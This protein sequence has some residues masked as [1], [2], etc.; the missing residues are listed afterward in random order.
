MGMNLRVGHSS[1]RARS[2]F[3]LVELLVVIAII[4]VLVALLLPA[5]Q[6]AREAARRMQCTNN[7]KQMG[8]GIH[9]FHDTNN[10]LP[11]LVR[12]PMRATFFVE[13][14]PFL[15]QTNAYNLL[16]GSNVN[17]TK[18]DIGLDMEQNWARLTIEER[19]ALGSIKY[20]TCPSRR[21]PGFRDVEGGTGNG[22]L[23]DYAAVFVLGD[24]DANG[25]F[26][27]A[28][29]DW[30]NHYN[31]CDTS[32]VARQKGALEVAQ[33]NCGE[34]NIDIRS[35]NA[36]PRS[37]FERMRDGTSNTFVL[38]EKHVRANEFG[39]CCAGGQ[40]DG[41]YLLQNGGWREYLVA[42][43]IQLRFG[44][45]PSDNAGNPDNT[46]G[47]GSYH[48]GVCH[49]LR[50]DGSVAS[51]SNNVSHNIVSRLG[52]VSDGFSVQLD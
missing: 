31:P 52:H 18:T 27:Q 36:R 22:P 1:G 6:A 39:K 44:K 14:M 4:G 19:K 21:A 29:G 38:G 28:V 49:F 9:N 47:F 35:R 37:G 24:P 10:G 13:I 48:P 34:A 26:S 8:L 32:H 23:G 15:E 12:G 16:N 7:I 46:F 45:G 41:T 20:M 3:T 33:V 43:N 40:T 11:P 42:R 25:N 50:G 30:W 2:A 51:V 17:A 5:V